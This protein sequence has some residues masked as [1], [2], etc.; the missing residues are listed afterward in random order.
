[1][2]YHRKIKSQ[3]FYRFIDKSG[4]EKEAVADLIIQA[5]DELALGNS[6]LALELLEAIL[7]RPDEK[8]AEKYEAWQKLKAAR[9]ENF[10][11]ELMQ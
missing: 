3:E 9:P 7:K 2:E 6:A 1:M 5:R 8:Q 10:R 11:L 4:K